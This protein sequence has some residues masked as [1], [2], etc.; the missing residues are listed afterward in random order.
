MADLHWT[1]VGLISWLHCASRAALRPIRISTLYTFTPHFVRVRDWLS[2]PLPYL[3]VPALPSSSPARPLEAP[4][5]LHFALSQ[6]AFMPP[7]DRRGERRGEERICIAGWK[8]EEGRKEDRPPIEYL[9]I[10]V[11]MRR[12]SFHVH[13]WGYPLYFCLGGGRGRQQGLQIDITVPFIPSF[14]PC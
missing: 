4:F 13:K 1:T 10:H 14:L 9:G 2:S 8:K 11:T 12:C 7:T 6:R 5:C 3:Y